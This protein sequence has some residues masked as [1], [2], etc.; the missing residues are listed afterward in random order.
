[1]SSWEENT[2]KQMFDVMR[3]IC[4]NK[5]VNVTLRKNVFHRSQLQPLETLQKRG[6][7]NLRDRLSAGLS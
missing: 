2:S 5:N 4:Y 1:M 3:L 6:K 7:L